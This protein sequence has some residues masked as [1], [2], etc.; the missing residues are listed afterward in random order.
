MN[1]L[2]IH[3]V[4]YT[5]KVLLLIYDVISYPFYTALQQPWKRVTKRVRVS[6]F[7]LNLDTLT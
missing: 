1:E 7:S 6:N 2:F 5:L 3:V 4:A